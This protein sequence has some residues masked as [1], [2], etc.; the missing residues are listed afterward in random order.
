MQH[1]ALK[2]FQRKG[3]TFR[4]RVHQRSHIWNISRTALASKRLLYALWYVGFFII[5]VQLHIN[6]FTWEKHIPAVTTWVEMCQVS[7]AENKASTDCFLLCC[8]IWK[9]SSLP[10]VL[11]SPSLPSSDHIK[12]QILSVIIRKGWRPWA[13]SVQASGGDGWPR[14]GFDG[15][16]WGTNELALSMA[17]LYS[18]LLMAKRGHQQEQHVNISAHFPMWGLLLCYHHTS[19]LIQSVHVGSNW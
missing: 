7:H 6:V 12:N 13:P 5:K 16:E 17:G 8:F 14:G 9:S 1:M 11:A 4:N 10:R 15:G 2:T 18:V 3:V 19:L